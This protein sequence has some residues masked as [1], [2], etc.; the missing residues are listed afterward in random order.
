MG[1]GARVAALALGLAA[2]SLPL[3][4][5]AAPADPGW[6]RVFR[7]DGK[8][9]TVYQPQ[10]DYWNGYTN[11]HFACAIAVSG[12]SPEEQFG[13][14]GEDA[15]TLMDRPARTVA[16]VATSRK[17]TFPNRPDDVVA[18]LR[19]VVEQLAPSGKVIWCRL[20]VWWPISIPQLSRTSAPW[21]STSIRRRS[22]TV[23]G[24]QCSSSSWASRNSS[25]W[26]ITG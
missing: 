2:A 1:Y 7:Q 16:L 24:P 5:P 17:V 6:P 20:T 18:S 8:Q 13:T 22:T 25:P 12:V 21:R 10:V 19:Q 26:R 14:V 23:P 15:L 11:L 4:A 3:T 9:L